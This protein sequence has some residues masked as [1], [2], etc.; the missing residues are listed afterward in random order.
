[1]SH[2]LQMITFIEYS[3]IVTCHIV[4]IINLYKNLVQINLK[5]TTIGSVYKTV[6]IYEYLLIETDDEIAYKLF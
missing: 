4:Q 5:F 2:S 3:S 1:M 6:S